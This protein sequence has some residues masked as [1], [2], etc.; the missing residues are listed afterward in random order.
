MMAFFIS[1]S[2]LVA[3][4]K[5]RELCKWWQVRQLPPRKKGWL[6][7]LWQQMDRG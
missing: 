2:L 7:L 4:L 5:L 3:G 6:V 1:T